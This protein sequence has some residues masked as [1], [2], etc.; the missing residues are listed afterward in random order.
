LLGNLPPSITG[1][2]ENTYEWLNL[3]SVL[4]KIKK[5]NNESLRT[6][7]RQLTINLGCENALYEKPV[8]SPTSKTQ[9]IFSEIIGFRWTRTCYD[10]QKLKTHWNGPKFGT[11]VQDGIKMTLA[12]GF[13]STIPLASSHPLVNPNLTKSCMCLK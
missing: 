2:L 10:H 3:A 6:S 12:L 9:Q 7:K 5:S 8:N 1:Q 13:A 4:T 11:W